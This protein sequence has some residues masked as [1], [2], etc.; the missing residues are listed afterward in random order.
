MSKE[1]TIVNGFL[2]RNP[3]SCGADLKG[4]LD[5]CVCIV[6]ATRDQR[7][8]LH[9]RFSDSVDLRFVP[10]CY[11][12]SRKVQWGNKSLGGFRFVVGYINK[13]KDLPINVVF[14]FEFINAGFVCFLYVSGVYA[15]YNL[16]EFWVSHY[17]GGKKIVDVYDFDS[18]CLDL[19][20]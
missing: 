9:Y 10:E 3:S 8:E 18:K 12:N 16:V 4:Q 15:D 5:K 2:L 20:I 19:L 7:S 14:D 6:S 1:E 17:C 11:K 13:D